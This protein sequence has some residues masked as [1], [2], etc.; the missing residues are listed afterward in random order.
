[1]SMTRKQFLGSLA[2]GTVVLWIQGC[3][4]GGSDYGGGGMNPTP[5]ST[6]GSSGA[7]ISGNHGHA[8]T[9]Q[10]TDLDSN[11]A[12]SYSIAGTAGHDHT[13]TL[14]PAQL[15]ALKTAGMTVTV[16]STTTDAHSHDVT[17]SCM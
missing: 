4:G 7:A 17:V 15:T 14:S 16:T 5:A 8:L 13:I 11:A 12:K 3:G 9:I 10:K 1:M 6:C 2:S